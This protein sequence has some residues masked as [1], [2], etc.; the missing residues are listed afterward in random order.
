[1]NKINREFSTLKLRN[2]SESA[3]KLGNELLDSKVESELLLSVALLSL[4]ES[5]EVLSASYE[6][7][8]EH[9]GLSNATEIELIKLML[10]VHQGLLRYL[11]RNP[12]K[13]E[14]IKV[15]LLD[16]TILYPMLVFLNEDLLANQQVDE[17]VK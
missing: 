8:N 11:I 4:Y 14:E 1:M 6:T 17:E 15:F 5:L 13:Y 10:N 16:L 3:K 7:Q 2:L 9:L 12:D